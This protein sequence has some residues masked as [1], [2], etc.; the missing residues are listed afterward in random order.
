MSVLG[1]GGVKLVAFLVSSSPIWHSCGLVGFD[2][3][4]F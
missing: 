1:V 3:G 4:A 2:A